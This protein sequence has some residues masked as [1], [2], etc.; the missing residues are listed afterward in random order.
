MT[1]R[2]ADR[3]TQA[4]LITLNDRSYPRAR[5]V[6]KN[7]EYTTHQQSLH[8]I[9]RIL[10]EPIRKAIVQN[11]DLLEREVVRGGEKGEGAGDEVEDDAADGPEVGSEW[12]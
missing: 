3:E 5:I 12:G 6:K 4:W 8:Q 10:V 11:L 9:P 7:Q 1:G 2:C